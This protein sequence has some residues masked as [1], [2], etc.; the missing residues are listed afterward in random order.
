MSIRNAGGRAIDAERS[1]AV[2]QL[3]GQPQ[4]VVLVQH[5]GE[6]FGLNS[7]RAGG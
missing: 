2:L 5:T 1:I 3:V 6:S 4:S 7:L